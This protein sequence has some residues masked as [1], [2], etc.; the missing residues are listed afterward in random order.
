MYLNDFL[1][2]SNSM[3]VIFVLLFKSAYTRMYVCW[4]LEVKNDTY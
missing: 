2:Y 1:I 3:Y 4:C